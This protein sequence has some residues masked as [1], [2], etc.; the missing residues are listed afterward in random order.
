M[1]NSFNNNNN[2]NNNIHNK[3]NYSY[4]NSNSNNSAGDLMSEMAQLVLQRKK[5]N[6]S[7]T[8]RVRLILEIERKVIY[9]P[10]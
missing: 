7:L 9:R 2:N 8:V 4:K 1:P 10:K 3:N 6:E 5:K